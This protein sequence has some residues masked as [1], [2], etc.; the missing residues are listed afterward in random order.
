MTEATLDRRSLA[1][2]MVRYALLAADPTPM[3][4][5]RDVAAVVDELGLS[6][7]E[8]ALAA[9]DAAGVMADALC[10]VYDVLRPHY[11]EVR[12]QLP[13]AEEWR[14]AAREDLAVMRL[15]RQ[16]SEVAG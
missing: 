13:T 16:L 14:E 2:N 4:R 8:A 10:Q 3:Q 1:A 5:V 11:P 7:A 15:E 6:E 12:S 9:I